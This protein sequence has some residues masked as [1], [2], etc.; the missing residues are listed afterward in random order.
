[1]GTAVLRR[2]AAALACV[3]A[4]AVLAGCGGGPP[5]PSAGPPPPEPVAAATTAAPVVDPETLPLGPPPEVAFL[6]N[7]VLQWQGRQVPTDLPGDAVYLTILGAVD[8]QV[9]VTGYQGR[10][11][12]AGERFWAI[13]RTGHARRLGGTYRSHDY[14]PRLVAPTG[15][16]WIQHTDRTGPRTIWEVDVRTGREVATYRGDEL[17]RGLAPTDQALIDA[18]VERRVAVPDTEATSPDGSLR[19]RTPTVSGTGPSVVVRAAGAGAVARFAFPATQ[20]GG[21]E[22]VVFEDDQRVLVLFTLSNTR[23]GGEQQV[24]VRCDVAQQ[25]CERATDVGGSMALG[26]VRPRF[27]PA[28]A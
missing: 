21:V 4:S 17:P 11:A 16:V 10:G 12:A 28:P 23:R 6:A 14:A 3:V 5:A 9:V 25:T 19:A 24:V 7:G 1:M 8:G 13:D 2:G 27:R 15:H 20:Y 22:R 26:V 18:W